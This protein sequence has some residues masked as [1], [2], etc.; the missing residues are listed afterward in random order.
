MVEHKKYVTKEYHEGH[1]A[2]EQGF[3]LTSNPYLRNN[4]DGDMWFWMFGWQDALAEDVKNIKA[5]IIAAAT[6]T[7]GRPN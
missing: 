2:Y 4:V 7:D 5:T 1:N 3:P 6:P